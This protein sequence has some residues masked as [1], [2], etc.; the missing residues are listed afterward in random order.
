MR[1][2]A[3]L[4]DENA[5]EDGAIRRKRDFAKIMRINHVTFKIMF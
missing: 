2:T 5:E 4:R 3:E 1:P